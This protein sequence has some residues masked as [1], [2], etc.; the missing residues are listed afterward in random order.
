[1]KKIMICIQALLA[2]FVLVS[3]LHDDNEL[4]NE[5]AAQRLDK[6]VEHYKQVLESA[7]NGWELQLWTEPSYSGG[8]YTYLMKFKEGKVTVASDL[9]DADKV[10]TSSYDITKDM[11]PVLTVNTYNE[12]FHSLANPSLSDDN[13]KGQDYEFM[14]QRVTNDSIFL[15]G[16]KFH[17]K[18][19]MTRLKDN[20]NWQNYISAMKNVADNVKVTYKYIAGQDTTLVNLSSARR[21]RFTIKDSVVTVPFCYTESGIELQKPVTI[22]N[23]QVKTMAY[24]IDNLT[25]T[26]SN[27][28]ATDV[29]F[30]TDFMRYADYEGTYNFEYQDGSIRVKMV[31]AGDGKTYW[32]E[33]LSSDFKLTFTY[34]KKTGT[35]TW[36]PEKVFTDANN[37]SIWMCSWDAADTK[38]VFK[39]DVL[40]F[41][42]NK[43]FT[44]PGVFLTFTSAY[45]GYINLDSMILMEYNGSKKVGKST[46]VLV[47]GSAEIAMIKGMTKI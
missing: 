30:T 11:G 27:S 45:A 44:K 4:F 12:I 7:N 42:V 40:G 24:N 20:V 46:T 15:E 36:G 16:K 28:G 41:V 47:N 21:A 23:K 2:S 39:F 37:R 8:G 31:P 5:S 13:G 19:V 3:C 33:G 1:M 32:L 10:A 6:A 22:A 26:G 18:M 38:Q 17:N 29:V 34:N 43:D 14:I 25:F 35:L 9:V